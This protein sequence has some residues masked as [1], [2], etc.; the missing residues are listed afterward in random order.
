MIKT[1]YWRT[2]KE[3]DVVNRSGKQE[4]LLH[5]LLVST[6]SLV[7]GSNFVTFLRVF[8]E[9]KDRAS[10]VLQNTHLMC[11]ISE[12]PLQAYYNLLNNLLYCL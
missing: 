3:E 7:F 11:A 8:L 2:R 10:A 6:A 1:C 12:F 4:W 5:K 9:F